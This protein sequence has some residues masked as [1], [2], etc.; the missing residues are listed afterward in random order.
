MTICCTGWE[1]VVVLA[2]FISSNDIH[3]RTVKKVKTETSS[4]SLSLSML[5]TINIMGL[6][7][8]DKFEWDTAKRYLLIA[9]SA[10]CKTQRVNSNDS[11]HRED[12][13][14]DCLKNII[15]ADEHDR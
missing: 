10:G 14:D 9:F 12:V 13:F 5:I 1:T 4:K 7:S 3:R 2:V 8:H 15:S 6:K 11:S